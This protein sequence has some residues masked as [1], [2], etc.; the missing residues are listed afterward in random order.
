MSDYRIQ[1]NV[2]L[3][4]INLIYPLEL[5]SQG[6]G[7]WIL[8]ASLPSSCMESPGEWILV[9]LRPWHL[10][11]TSWIHLESLK[12]R[13]EADAGRVTVQQE[14]SDGVRLL[15]EHFDIQMMMMNQ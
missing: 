14:S 8:P 15:V 3:E 5:T 4:I 13:A 1:C 2:Q 11:M 10:Q 12:L 9:L 7:Q 6:T